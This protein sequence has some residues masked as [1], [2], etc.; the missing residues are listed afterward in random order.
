[1]NRSSGPAARKR[2]A[3]KKKGGS[4]STPT[5]MAIQVS[6]QIVDITMKRMIAQPL[7]SARGDSAKD[8]SN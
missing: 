7:E 4:T 6:P 5:R 1:M 2:D 8:A 3:A